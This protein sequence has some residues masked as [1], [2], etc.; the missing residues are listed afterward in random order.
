MQN[1][2]FSRIMKHFT[3]LFGSQKVSSAFGGNP[4]EQLAI[5]EAWESQ[6]RSVDPRVIRMALQ[7]LTDNPPAW[8]PSLA[9]WIQLCRQFD[10]PEHRAVLP[11]PAFA[12]TE[13]GKEISQQV[14]QAFRRDNFDYLAWAKY[15]GS[16]QAVRLLARGAKTDSRLRDILDHLIATDGQDCRRDDAREEIRKLAASMRSQMAAQAY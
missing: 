5:G 8:P 16:M 2:Y 1:A 13:V 4:E 15:P 6:L 12:P 11:A 14:S 7:S 9:E 3:V 10:R